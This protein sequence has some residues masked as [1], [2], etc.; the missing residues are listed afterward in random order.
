MGTSREGHS[1]SKCGGGGKEGI[2]ILSSLLYVLPPQTDGLSLVLDG[3]R[4]R[5]GVHHWQWGEHK[6]NLFLNP[7]GISE[8]P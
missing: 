3:H 4:Q 2:G 5:G 7:L 6:M 1:S 8:F